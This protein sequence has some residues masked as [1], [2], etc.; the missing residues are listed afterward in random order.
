MAVQIQLRRGTATQWSS[1]NPI[2]AIGELGVET[3]T[4][5]FKVGD[6]INRWLN[7]P[8]AL[9]QM[10]DT[11]SYIS[12]S[13]IFDYQIY[14]LTS[15]NSIS[16]SYSIQS[17]YSD[18]ASYISSSATFDYQIYNLTSSNSIQSI[19]AESASWVSASVKIIASDTASYISSSAIFDYQIYNLTSSNS[20][21]TSYALYSDQSQNATQSIY[22]ESASWV[23][24]S[25][26]I[27]TADTA[28]YITGGPFTI[29]VTD[30]INNSDASTKKYVDERLSQNSVFY[31][32]ATSSGIGFDYLMILTDSNP[33]TITLS[34]GSV[35]NNDYVFSW[36]TQPNI[37][38]V[39]ILPEG[40]YHID[41]TT[42]KTGGVNTCSIYP[43][44]YIA[45]LNGVEY[46]EVGT[47]STPS[48]LTTTFTRF[49]D[50]IAVTSPVTMSVTDRLVVKLKIADTGNDTIETQV[51]GNTL[52]HFGTPISNANF[53]T[54]IATSSVSISASY[55]LTSSYTTTASYSISASNAFT[56]SYAITASNSISASY[57]L[58]SSYATTASYSV[59]SSY[60]SVSPLGCVLALC[61]AYTPIASGSD[62]AEIP[63]PY[64]PRDGISSINWNVRRL[65]MRVQTAG[66]SSVVNIE[67]STTT[68]GFVASTIGILTLE[69]GS[70]E[71]YNSS[72]LGTINSGDKIRFNVTTLGTAQNWTITTELG[73]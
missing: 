12:S 46:Y 1:S 20:I 50:Y 25:V 44:I 17:I 10:A 72:S 73:Q 42:R 30:P 9:Y 16:A 58:T 59:S 22:A 47:T 66:T 39:T 41:H 29:T 23:S 26:K 27:T 69:S 4:S 13:A 64:S 45:D 40:L 18:T 53:I 37:P 49:T 2:L 5:L 34:T 61:A 8:Y 67:K 57:A 7:R 48:T 62:V 21:S 65:N 3:N 63:V 15:S 14:N 51:E 60:A 19:Y 71:A 32:S 68:N 70:Y 43:E 38:N 6:G 36:I 54:N 33:S 35:G 11:G 52:S 24:A 31:L 56:S 55:A 28:S